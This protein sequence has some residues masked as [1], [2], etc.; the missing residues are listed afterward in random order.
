MFDFYEDDDFFNEPSEFEQQVEEFK[1]SLKKSVKEEFLQRMEALEKENAALREF[2]DQRDRLIWE[3][4]PK[5]AKAEREAKEAEV[6][7]KKARLHQLLGDFLTTGWKVDWTYEQGPK[8]DKCD[9]NRLIHFK[10]PQGRDHKEECDCAKKHNRFYPKEAVLS[11]FHVRKKNFRSDVDTDW[12]NRYYTVESQ[13]EY[14]RYETS[15]DVYESGFVCEKVTNRYRAV[16]LSEEDCQRYCDWLNEQ[17]A[18]KG[19]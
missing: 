5:V 14:D 9:E 17:E 15:S 11:K 7:W 16:F 4:D 2:R 18:K 12:F 13:D 1:G 6:K 3:C 19:G 8:C 10:S